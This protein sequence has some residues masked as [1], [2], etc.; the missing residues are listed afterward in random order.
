MW[1]SV[2]LG[3]MGTSNDEREPFGVTL[4]SGWGYRVVDGRTIYESPDDT[5]RVY[6]VEFSRG[7]RIYWWAEVCER[8]NGRWVVVDRP[9]DTFRDPDRVAETLSDLLE[10]HGSLASAPAASE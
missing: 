3:T 8:R 10:T 7:L 5:T 1:W 6:V 9:G 2:T 4:P